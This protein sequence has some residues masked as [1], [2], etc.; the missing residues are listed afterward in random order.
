MTRP[1]FQKFVEGYVE[2][3]RCYLDRRVAAQRQGLGKFHTDANAGGSSEKRIEASPKKKL[4]AK[5]E[6]RVRISGAA[7]RTAAR[8]KPRLYLSLQIRFLSSLR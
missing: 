7:R 4:A 3:R 1:Y 8:L 5:E 2:E 6:F